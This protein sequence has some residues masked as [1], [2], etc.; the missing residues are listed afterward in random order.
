MSGEHPERDLPEGGV[1]D[2][3]SEAQGVGLWAG[4]TG[5]LHDASRRALLRLL[6]GPYVSGRANPQLW[7]ALVAD[8]KAIRSRL[9]DLF[10]DLVIDRVDEFAF[11]RKVR[12][13][14]T[15]VPQALRS[16]RLT[17]VD[18]AM[19]LVLRQ[20]LLSAAGEP[21][22]I[23]GQEEVYERLSVYRD[24][25]ESTYLRNLNG[26]WTRMKNRFRVLHDVG[27]DRVEISP[28][29]KF[30]IDEEQVGALSQVYARLAESGEPTADSSAGEPGEEEGQT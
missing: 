1:P 12:T 29:V 26:A 28:V 13:T 23:V 7:A 17:F 9:H 5:T 27:E 19:L 6:Q 3:D 8:E 25:D 2:L 10:L 4:D 15:D 30:L 11:T 21:R 24:G 16:E 22:V 18:T 20:L 14:Q